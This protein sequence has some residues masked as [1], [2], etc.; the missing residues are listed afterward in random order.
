MLLRREVYIEIKNRELV[1]DNTSLCLDGLRWCDGEALPETDGRLI[2]QTIVV[3]AKFQD[4][5]GQRTMVD[6]CEDET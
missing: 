2:R 1:I 4:N 5:R 6:G 3:L